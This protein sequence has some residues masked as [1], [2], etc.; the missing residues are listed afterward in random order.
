MLSAPAELV[1]EAAAPVPLSE[2][3]LV[4]VADSEVPRVALLK[5]VF[6]GRAVPVPELEAAA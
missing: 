6:R 1:D 4:A 3:P 5:V 2:D